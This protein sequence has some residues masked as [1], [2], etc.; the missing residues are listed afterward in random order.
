M[1]N[2]V[3][4][5]YQDMVPPKIIFRMALSMHYLILGGGKYKKMKSSHKDDR[6]PEGE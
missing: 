1:S 6:Q 2:N 5:P 4:F 3:S